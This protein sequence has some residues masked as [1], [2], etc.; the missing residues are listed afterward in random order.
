MPL[1]HQ[2]LVGIRTNVDEIWWGGVCMCQ[3]T[4]AISSVSWAHGSL[5]NQG[6]GHNPPHPTRQHFQ[7]TITII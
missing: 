7:P 3:P 4:I 2:I 1:T 6:H 5:A